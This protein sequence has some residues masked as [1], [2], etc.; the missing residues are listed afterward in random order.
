MRDL[1]TAIHL[2]ILGNFAIS[3]EGGSNSLSMKSL[4][5]SPN[6]IVVTYIPSSYSNPD[7][8]LR[9][10]PLSS[11][12]LQ[13]PTIYDNLQAEPELVLDCDVKY[14]NGV[15]LHITP[16]RFTVYNDAT[17]HRLSITKIAQ[18]KNW[19][20]DS[21]GIGTK[22]F[23]IKRF[24]SG[25]ELSNYNLVSFIKRNGVIEQYSVDTPVE[26]Y[27]F[28]YDELMNWIVQEIKNQ[29]EALALDSIS[30]LLADSNYPNRF[31]INVGTTLLTEKG[32]RGFIDDRDEIFT[33][34]YDRTLYRASSIKAY[35]LA[36]KTRN[37]NYDGMVI[38]HQTAHL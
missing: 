7:S 27:A 33:I 23:D 20:S 16:K 18:N 31:L 22:W 15:P 19:G 1:A 36:Y 5:G 24:E 32:D 12:K 10:N 35:I 3:D 4:T 38:L 11:S 34:L 2:G 9:V 17:L 37:I 13:I 25:G 14:Y 26:N 8:F 28:F 30:N 21:K 6:G 29:K